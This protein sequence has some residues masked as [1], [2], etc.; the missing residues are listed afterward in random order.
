MAIRERG[1]GVGGWGRLHSASEGGTEM[2]ASIKDV[3]KSV[4]KKK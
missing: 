3:V 4:M 1:S 2:P